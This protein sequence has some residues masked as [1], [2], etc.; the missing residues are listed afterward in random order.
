MWAAYEKEGVKPKQDWRQADA[1]GTMQRCVRGGLVRIRMRKE[2]EAELRAQEREKGQA[3]S[4][5]RGGDDDLGDAGGGKSG[6]GKAGAA[7]RARASAWMDYHLSTFTS[8]D[9]IYGDGDFMGNL[10]N[11]LVR[12]PAEGAL[13]RAH[14]KEARIQPCAETV[15]RA[16]VQAM[17]QFG[18]LVRTTRIIRAAA[19]AYIYLRER[20]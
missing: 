1:T 15:E 11:N 4:A 7:A 16:A 9:Q 12:L 18:R 17:A 19:C 3:S 10:M 2:R 5:E 20:C 14:G 6:G 13:V 8:G